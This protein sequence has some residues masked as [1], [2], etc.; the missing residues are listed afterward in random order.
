MKTPIFSKKFCGESIPFL[1]NFLLPSLKILGAPQ[2]RI[3]LLAGIPRITQPS[4]PIFKNENITGRDLPC[5]VEHLG[6]A[7]DI[8]VTGIGGRKFVNPLIMKLTFSLTRKSVKKFFHV[9]ERN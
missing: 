6:R 4:C 8:M 3:N 2:G 5:T 7:S 1:K 9:N